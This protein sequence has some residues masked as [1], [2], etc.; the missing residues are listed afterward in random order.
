MKYSEMQKC[1]KPVPHSIQFD[2]YQ[3]KYLTI[4]IQHDM[5]RRKFLAFSKIS[6]RHV[7][8]YFY[9]QELITAEGGISIK[10]YL[11]FP[12]SNFP[13]IEHMNLKSWIFHEE[14]SQDFQKYRKQF[15]CIFGK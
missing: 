1:E 7:K 4:T 15:Y 8:Y 14:M 11:C 2:H 9:S 10:M 5:T 12:S 13:T 3:P 6:K